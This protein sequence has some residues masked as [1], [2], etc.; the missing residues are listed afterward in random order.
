MQNKKKYLAFL[1]L[2]FLLPCL[3]GGCVGKFAPHYQAKSEVHYNGQL[4][5]TRFDYTGAQRKGLSANQVEG[6]PISH[7]YLDIPVQKH[8]EQAFEAEMD[9]VGIRNQPGGAS[10]R[11]SVARLLSDQVSLGVKWI[12]EVDY[13]FFNGNQPIY[14]T[15]IR[16]DKYYS[17]FSNPVD[18]INEL[19]RDNFDQLMDD[20]QVR[21]IVETGRP[22]VRVRALPKARH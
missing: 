1:L 8:M 13:E 12:L 11:G 9:R 7:I 2:P 18:A 14:G 6:I 10:L 3:L 17:K 22:G 20:P 19:I 16:S 15:H 5:V 4:E 21:S